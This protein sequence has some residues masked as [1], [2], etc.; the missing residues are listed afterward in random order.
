MG[1][2]EIIYIISISQ[3]RNYGKR[4]KVAKR[5]GCYAD[6]RTKR[7]SCLQANAPSQRR[8]KS[9]RK[10]NG[11]RQSQPQKIFRVN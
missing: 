6:N 1:I 9:G 10:A 4:K 3:E 2:F 5:T 8:T 11:I 7:C